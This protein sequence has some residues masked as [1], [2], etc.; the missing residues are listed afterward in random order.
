M[1]RQRKGLLILLSFVMILANRSICPLIVKAE[2]GNATQMEEYWSFEYTGA[3]QTFTAPYS[4]VYQLEVY[5]AQGGSTDENA[6]GKG[7]GVTASVRLSKNEEIAIFIG[8]SDG[9]NGGGRGNVSNG[10]GATD[11]RKNGTNLADRILI[12]G[13]GGG[14]NQVYSGKEGGSTVSTVISENGEGES[15]AEGAGGGSGNLGGSAGIEH[16]VSHIHQGDVWHGGNCYSADYHSHEGNESVYG[17]CY[18]TETIKMVNTVHNWHVTGRGDT[19][20]FDGEI[21]EGEGKTYYISTIYP[22]EDEHG[23]TGEIY[24][25]THA[26]GARANMKHDW[27][28]ES[29]TY[30]NAGGKLVEEPLG[31]IFTTTKEIPLVCYDT[32]CGQTEN[33]ITGY[34]INCKKE[35]DEYE[36]KQADGGTS[37]YDK[38][39]CSGVVSEAGIRT[40]NGACYIRLLS[41][42]NLFYEGQESSDVYYD[43]IQVKKIYY[44]GNLIYRK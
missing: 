6:G 17:G 39:I 1:L 36:V 8:G 37:Y 26:V 15:A 9:Y 44:K 31:H 29:N 3:E 16:V 30:G 13:G 12:A 21:V 28:F 11:I 2:N 35:Y 38:D 40:G 14:A 43:G 5:G 24:W 23:H 32:G 25:C 4:G 10:G 33:T 18:I 41:L 34:H 20:S 27:A 19:I 22:V 42:H 7:G